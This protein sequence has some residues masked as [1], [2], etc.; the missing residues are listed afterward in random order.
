M[1]D[2]KR[3]ITEFIADNLSG[4]SVA[5]IPHYLFTLFLVGCWAWALRWLFLRGTERDAEDKA[6]GRQLVILAI[7]MT[8][9]VVVIRFSIPL[10]IA[11]AGMLALIRFKA[12]TRNMRELTYVLL[13]FV[14]ALG[15]GGGYAVVT[16]LG[17]LVLIPVLFLLQKKPA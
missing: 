4:F 16:S 6:F 13:T 17:F 12:Q 10:A 1:D 8:I 5:D 11:F 9:A 2:F 14:L 15:C 3:W 7:G